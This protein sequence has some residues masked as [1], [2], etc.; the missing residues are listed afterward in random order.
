MTSLTNNPHYN[1]RIEF[2]VPT[3]N[4]HSDNNKEIL[5]CQSPKQNT[6]ATFPRCDNFPLLFFHPHEWH[7]FTHFAIQKIFVTITSR[8]E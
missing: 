5:F 4:F 6:Y 2:I 3:Q 1:N 7:C 8:V